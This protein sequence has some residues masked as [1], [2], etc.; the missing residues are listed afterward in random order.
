MQFNGT[1]PENSLYEDTLYWSGATS[2]LYPADPD[3]TRNANFA[4]D[5]IDSLI[6][7]ADGQ[8]Q[9]DDANR[10]TELIDTSI[11]LVAGTVKYAIL[12]SWL[13]IARFRVKDPNGNWITLKP[14]DRRQLSD[15]ELEETGTPRYYDKLGNF[16]YL[17]P[18]P[19]YSS[20]GGG[21]VQLQRGS[22]HFVVGDTT[23]EPGF[24]PQFHRLV[25]LYAALDYTEPNDLDARSKVIRNRIEPLEA[26]LMEFYARRDN[27]E[28][29][30]LGLRQEDYGQH[31]FSGEVLPKGF[32][33]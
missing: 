25:S 11:N 7:K 2:T 18:I 19:N 31:S 9:H 27:D 16:L 24:A 14:K 5:R 3:F 30:N 28:V 32:I 4:L 23:K 29:P 17:Y 33:F 12:T 20:T 10:S 15:T 21:E 6:L 13:K 8:W 22:D 26:E 1:D